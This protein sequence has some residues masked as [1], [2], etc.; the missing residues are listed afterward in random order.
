MIKR[1]PRNKFKKVR[2]DTMKINKKKLISLLLLIVILVLTS[3][4]STYGKESSVKIYIN[5][6]II[7]SDQEPVIVKSRVLVPIRVIAENM[8]ATVSYEAKTKRVSIVK[9][10]I[11]MTLVIG[12]STIWYSDMEKSGPVMIDS[13]AKIK[14]GRTMIPL[15]AVAELFDMDVRWDGKER[16]VYIDNKYAPQDL[17]NINNAGNEVLE[18][19]KLKGTLDKGAYVSEV[20]SSEVEYEGIME[21]GFKVTL[22]KDN[23]YDS[24][25]TELVGHYFIDRSGGLV[26]VYDVIT[27]T[28]NNILL[29]N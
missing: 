11:S 9:D 19:L 17:I 1:I 23:P 14:N 4:N 27:D 25:L 28:Y 13:P 10:E 29:V 6:E 26:L 12:E 7:Y 16:A 5:N 2:G 24:Y 22:R 8:G 15:R 3:V 21:R 18:T 20:M